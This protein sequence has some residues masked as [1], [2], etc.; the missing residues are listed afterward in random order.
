MQLRPTLIWD[1]T[2]V[3]MKT[4]WQLADAFHIISE[5]RRIDHALLWVIVKDPCPMY[6]ELGTVLDYALS[7]GS[8]ESPLE[9]ILQWRESPGED[10]HWMHFISKPVTILVDEELPLKGHAQV[11]HAVPSQLACEQEVNTFWVQNAKSDEKNEILCHFADNKVVRIDLAHTP[12]VEANGIVHPALQA[13]DIRMGDIRLRSLTDI[14]SR[15]SESAAWNYLPAQLALPR[16]PCHILKMPFNATRGNHAWIH[17]A[18]YPLVQ[19]NYERLLEQS[20]LTVRL[21]YALQCSDDVIAQIFEPE[22]PDLEHIL[23]L[24]AD[25]GSRSTRLLRFAE[26]SA[27]WEQ[28]YNLGAFLLFIT[29]QEPFVPRWIYDPESHGGIIQAQWLH[30]LVKPWNDGTALMTDEGVSRYLE[31]IN[32]WLEQQ[33][34]DAFG[35]WTLP[36]WL[37]I[38]DASGHVHPAE[39]IE[40]HFA[41]ILNIVWPYDLIVSQ[42]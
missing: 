42:E 17:E 37:S 4:P 15:P 38:M 18:I 1:L 22:I 13:M 19:V 3:E 23:R 5:L 29:G 24:I 35:I 25:K 34:L 6:H 36:L 14:L 12:V 26:D 2:Q 40:E 28:N 27:D 11:L 39:T 9:I 10:S 7:H 16:T 20:A 32:H 8:D 30:Q 21:L 31:Q 33:H 41:S